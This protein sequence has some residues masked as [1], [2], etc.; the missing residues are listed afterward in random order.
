MR[1]LHAAGFVLLI[2]V[3]N[4]PAGARSADVAT[5]RIGL[6]QEP[7]TLNPVI[8]TLAVESDIAQLIFDGLTR[9][10]ERGNHVPDLATVVPTRAN[11]GIA[12]DGRSIT[13]HLVHNAR[14]QDGVPLTSADVAFTFSALTNTRN[15]V[16]NTEPYTEMKRIETPDPYT[17]RVVLKHPWA[18]AIDGFSDRI[19]GAILPAHLLEHEAD[20]NR[21]DFNALPIGSGPYRLVAWHRG[22][23]MTFEANRSYFRGPPKI[24]RVVVRFLTNDNTMLVAVR[25][26]ELDLADHLNISTYT[27]LG[28]VAGM[29]PAINAQS[30][31]EHLTFNTRRPPLE[32]RRVRLALCY[33][34]DVHEIF[35]KVAHGLGA[36][37]PTNQNPLTPWYNRRIA[38]YPFDP[39]KAM[40][41]LDDAGWKRGPDGVRTKNG[42]R[43]SITL[44][45]P[46][47]NITRDQTGVLLQARWQRIGVETII[48]TYP[49]Q[50]FFAPADA[51]GPFYGGKTDVTLSAFVNSVPD[52]TGVNENAAD[53]IPPHG[54]NLSFFESAELTRLEN[55]A[56]ATNVLGD[57]KALYD[58]IQEIEIRELPYYVLRWAEILDMRSTTLRG[59]KPPVV[60]S[61]FWNIA[62]WSL[63]SSP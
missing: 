53:H 55:A 21:A 46:A 5:L 39:D 58:R 2:A 54:N 28:T 34:F 1:G 41:L 26:G 13:Y 29:I 16:A 12:V 23:D 44:S 19:D 3:L 59:V 51:G 38:Y 6:T 4:L 14:W 17:V 57:R 15:N 8:G 52:P 25:T 62:D 33:G 30:Y 40:K 47:G 35:A 48:K 11:G 37:G 27:G 50:T 63:A 32:D 61:T 43:L 60:N 31:W 9:Y 7:G 45:F 56:A 18:P 10:D 36:L 20:L 24:D 22:S 42:A 49:A